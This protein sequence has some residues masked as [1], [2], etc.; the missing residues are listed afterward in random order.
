MPA[1][2]CPLPGLWDAWGQLRVLGALGSCARRVHVS[3]NVARE[4]VCRLPG[5]SSLGTR[6]VWPRGTSRVHREPGCQL[7]L[8][9]AWYRRVWQT[10]VPTAPRSH[11]MLCRELLGLCPACCPH[12]LC[13]GRED[14]PGLCTCSASSCPALEALISPSLAQGS[15]SA[16]LPAAPC[17]WPGEWWEAGWHMA[18]G[19]GQNVP[20]S[21]GGREG[22][23]QG[24]A[25]LHGQG[26][27]HPAKRGRSSQAACQGSA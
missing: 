20:S 21:A 26:K 5:R 12:L 13:A 17:W 23:W 22:A 3:L 1:C 9:S 2:A 15:G 10:P 18:E 7:G 24:T 25:V 8:H 16:H 19:V 6:S 4:H 27:H 14:P 11:P